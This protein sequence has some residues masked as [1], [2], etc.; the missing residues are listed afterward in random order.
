[1]EIFRLGLSIQVTCNP[2]SILIFSTQ[3]MEV[4]KFSVKKLHREN[5]VR[6][7]ADAEA[8]SLWE[9]ALL[10][11][12][13]SSGLSFSVLWDTICFCFS[14]FC[15]LRMNARFGFLSSCHTPL[16]TRGVCGSAIKKWPRECREIEVR[17]GQQHLP[18]SLE[19]LIWETLTP[20]SKLPCC[21]EPK[22][23]GKARGRAWMDSAPLL[24]TRL[25]ILP[26]VDPSLQAGL[27]VTSLQQQSLSVKTKARCTR[28]MPSGLA[29]M[30]DS[31]N[32]LK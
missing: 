27:S 17:K 3:A 20:K 21:E 1:M 10:R 24:T 14:R 8:V 6:H 5:R 16:N 28:H 29:H 12:F 11:N 26:P 9:A 22:P 18:P 31:Q 7:I 30:P 13:L 32:L 15:F 25:V 19:R 4:W 23:H 2:I